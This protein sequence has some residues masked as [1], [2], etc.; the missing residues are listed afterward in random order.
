MESLPIPAEE[1]EGPGNHAISNQDLQAPGP[2]HGGLRLVQVQEYH[3]KD[4]LPHVHNLLEQFDLEVG[5]P[6]TVTMF[7]SSDLEYWK[8]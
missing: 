1:A 8:P 2:V 6:C 5:G 4:L 7:K 3:L